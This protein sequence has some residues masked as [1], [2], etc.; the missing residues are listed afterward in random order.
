MLCSRAR[1]LVP[2]T[3]ESTLRQSPR[4][5][6]GGDS[7]TPGWSEA[8]R[9]AGLLI[10][11][12]RVEWVELSAIVQTT[13][14]IESA[15][16]AEIDVQVAWPLA[17]HRRSERHWASEA[18]GLPENVRARI[19]HRVDRRG[20]LSRFLI[21]LGFREALLAARL[22]GYGRL[23]LIDDYDTSADPTGARPQA[24]GEDR[25]PSDEPPSQQEWAGYIVPLRWVAGD[26]LATIRTIAAEVARVARISGRG[27]PSADAEAIARVLMFELVGNV[28]S[29]AQAPRA[30]V[31]AFAHPYDVPPRP[32]SF[33]SC[34]RP[35]FQW[36]GAQR[37]SGIDIVV[38]DSGLGLPAVLGPAYERAREHGVNVPTL[39]AGPD[40]SVMQW[41]FDR[42]SSSDPSER[43]GTRGL[44]R[45]DRVVKRHAGLMT[46][47]AAD[48]LVGFDHGGA[49]HDANLV[50]A[51]ALAHVPGTVLHTHVPR[52]KDDYVAR[53]TTHAPR[54]L[55]FAFRSLAIGDDGGITI[56][57]S[58]A[59]PA[60]GDAGPDACVV[61]VPDREP[62]RKTTV[63]Q[64]ISAVADARGPAATAIVGLPS[65]DWENV[66]EACTSLNL[67]V[68]EHGLHRDHH[69]SDDAPL[70][71]YDV[72]DPV[73]VLGTGPG[74]LAWTGAPP[75]IAALLERL[76][77]TDGGQ[78]RRAEIAS[79]E[80]EWVA[81]R[82]A[83]RHDT[84]VVRLH[85]DAIELRVHPAALHQAVAERMTTRVA[86]Q[87]REAAGTRP[88]VT[89]SLAT[90][91]VWLDV[92]KLL[93]DEIDQIL[94][95]GCLA[96]LLA[97]DLG[98]ARTEIVLLSDVSALRSVRKHL[99]K[100]IG[101]VRHD[102]IPS[103]VSSDRADVRVK[104]A[105]QGEAVI[106]YADVISSGEAVR[107]TV[108][109]VMRDGAQPLA[110]ACLA[111]IRHDAG[112]P[113]SVWGTEVRVVSLACAALAFDPDTVKVDPEQVDFLDPSGAVERPERPPPRYP[114]RVRKLKQLVVEQEALHFGHVGGSTGRHFSFYVNAG[115]LLERD[116]LKHRLVDVVREWDAEA[117]EHAG[118][119]AD[120]KDGPLQVWYP[121]PEPKAPRPARNLALHLAATRR[122]AVA[123]S[124]R[125]EPA[126]GGW[127]FPSAV[128]DLN[129]GTAVA[130]VDWG[131]IEGTT[132]IEMLRL[133]CE[134]GAE[135]VLVCLCLSQLPHDEERHLAALTGMSVQRQVSPSP[136]DDRGRSALL[137]EHDA[138]P[139]PQTVDHDVSVRVRFLSA[140]AVPAYTPRDC[141]VCQQLVEL[142][143]QEAPTQ[144]LA[145][146]LEDQRKKRLHLTPRDDA[147]SAPIEDLDRNPLPSEAVVKMLDRRHELEAALR[148]TRARHKLAAW[149]E[150]LDPEVPSGEGL[151]LM[152]LLAVETQ[153]LRRPP[154]VF[155]RVRGNLADLAAGI[156]AAPDIAS[157]DRVN[158]IVVLRTCSRSAFADHGDRIFVRVHADHAAL[159]QLLYGFHAHIQRPYLRAPAV[160]KA[161]ADALGRIRRRI[162]VGEIPASAG[163]QEIEL[164]HE[165]ASARGRAARVAETPVTQ[166][167]SELKRALAT[168]YPHPGV[169]DSVRRLAPGLY[170]SLAEAFRAGAQL[171]ERQREHERFISQ[172][173]PDDWQSVEAFLSDEV[174]PR[175]QRLNGMLRSDTA[176]DAFGA[177]LTRVQRLI[178][179]GQ[180]VAEWPIAR[181]MREVGEDVR[182]LGRPYVWDRLMSEYRWLTDVLLGPD[183]DEH[184]MR[185]RLARL[186]ELVPTP[187]YAT[188]K[189]TVQAHRDRHPESRIATI[190]IDGA[191]ADAF[192]P[193][194]DVDVFFPRN[195]LRHLLEQILRNVEVHHV[196][197]DGPPA[198][199]WIEHRDLGRYMLMKVSN[200]ATQPSANPG[201]LLAKYKQELPRF[202]GEIE[203]NRSSDV[204]GVTYC[205]RVRLRTMES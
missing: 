189:Q 161:L 83:L 179:E 137:D 31:A 104:V 65:T 169:S 115:R 165:R 96:H 46:I 182:R 74:E 50:E 34:E 10:D 73:L 191:P 87:A 187:L 122:H 197:A 108:A 201:R 4:V 55:A 6:G 103:D 149:L 112:R 57:G 133:A 188:V 59:E 128:G 80:D 172:Q 81:I 32:E 78:L 21:R 22:D 111:D 117:R 1:T 23:E 43:R 120:A 134:A 82:R 17:N 48:Q 102:E 183:E 76:S 62:L 160:W 130:I 174:L 199:V 97:D 71:R 173:I 178:A 163:G 41:A 113:L 7:G 61:L 171:D 190:E 8:V 155:R 146:F 125:R 56:E 66:L 127:K 175:L 3:L 86:D 195:A 170:G 151:N 158:A 110:V 52:Q 72:L 154:L 29:H 26:D 157:A 141:P 204:A 132:A 164:L 184:A 194:A 54:D 11:L 202:E 89:A 63:E 42:R 114:M 79:D 105:A 135:R 40:A 200:T 98:R 136:V 176:R 28:T 140:L 45:V 18:G 68:E 99:S 24:G 44:Y 121:T 167:W 156:A 51:T 5:Y 193:A 142:S 152:R 2:A 181:L 33:L 192:A 177:Q 84:N 143:E 145:S 47:R 19:K 92:D 90:V 60:I 88:K 180:A 16:R 116:A 126:W 168:D 93:A 53:E 12:S 94:A 196:G 20:D 100:A 138:P 64:L 159:D 119:S 27:I 123:R 9:E 36:F 129:P 153:W 38:G 95:V 77:R 109:Q 139:A 69:E 75:A 131:A 30:L 162:E 13:V 106:V 49:A 107:A 37:L 35:Y 70:D 203:R 205:V 58:P 186:L 198:R 85:D 185:S 147:I 14:L 124:I 150:R 166:A 39:E 101:A 148:S 67:E 25:E 118:A 91:P 15:L 144:R